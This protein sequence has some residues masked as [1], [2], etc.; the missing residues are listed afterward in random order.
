MVR[1]IF[2]I[3]LTIIT[4]SLL[5]LKIYAS[6]DVTKGTKFIVLGHIYPIMNDNNKVQELIKKINLHKADYVFILGD[7]RLNQANVIKEFKNKIIGKTFY[8][9]GNH[10]VR[11]YKEDYEK[12]VGYLNKLI[13]E[14]DIRFILLNSSDSLSNVKKFLEKIL[15][16]NFDYGPTIILT[17]HRIWDDT[18]IGDKSYS[19]DKSFYFDEIFPV[20][21]G[22]IKA[23]F[24]GNSKRQ[25]FRD[26][27]DDGLGYGKQNVN[28]IYWLDKIKNID[29][30]SVG[31]GDG[32]PKANFVIIEVVKKELY[33]KGDYST[34]RNYDILPRNLVEPDVFRLNINN[35]KGIREHVAE[36]YYLINKNKK[37]ILIF[38]IILI[39]TILVFR[40]IKKK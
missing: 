17:H 34:T 31:M 1:K 24:S 13:E 12:N 33:V 21:D 3:L 30:Y 38:I 2:T 15:K 16:E 26:L 9:P 36:K 35:T 7:S 11:N 32:D 8:S 28:L 37:F 4:L 19:H 29:L 5:N 23:I 39:F 10:E 20:V 25:Y 27:T 18:L 22:K 40:L 14:K 6:D